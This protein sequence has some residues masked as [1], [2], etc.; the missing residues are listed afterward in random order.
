[1]AGEVR[2]GVAVCDFHT[3]M[4]IAMDAAAASGARR[5]RNLEGCV[6]GWGSFATI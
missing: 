1:M 6:V 2:G 5:A 4:A 3:T